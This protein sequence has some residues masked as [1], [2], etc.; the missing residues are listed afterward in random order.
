MQN[1]GTTKIVSPCA[2]YQSVNLI[3]G[4]VKDLMK[5]KLETSPWESDFETVQ[6][7]IAADK[8][9]LSIDLDPKNIKPNPG[10]RAVG[11]ICL[12]SLWGKFGQRQNMTQTKYVTDA[13]ECYKLL[14]NDKI[15]CIQLCHKK[16][17]C[18]SHWTFLRSAKA[19]LC[20]D[21]TRLYSAS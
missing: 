2:A 10:K 20:L 1:T 11:N 6:D 3:K 18:K 12:N 17:L 16:V 19:V 8:N 21:F 13:K 15:E 5:I 9:C 7:Y 14:L 4:Y